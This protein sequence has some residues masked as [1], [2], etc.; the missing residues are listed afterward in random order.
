MISTRA[1]EEMNRASKRLRD[2]IGEKLSTITISSTSSDEAVFLGQN[3]SK[4]S[5]LIGNLIE[6]RIPSLLSQDASR[7]SLK[8]KRQDP[9]FPDAVLFD[10]GT[11]TG[12][13]FEVKAWFPMTTEI[14]GRF[15]ESQ[16]LLAGKDIRVAVVA[17]M[18]SDIVFGTPQIVGILVADAL[19]IAR[20]RDQHYHNPPYYICE[21][22]QD[23][24][25]RTR[26]LQQ[27]NV[28]GFKL[29]D[30]DIN[31]LHAVMNLS[32]LSDAT[33]S[34]TEEGRALSRDLLA[35][36]TYRQDSNFAK[37]DRIKHPEVEGFK[38]NI[39]AQ[40]FRGRPIADWAKDVRTLT[41]NNDKTPAE[42]L[43]LAVE[44]IEGLYGAQHT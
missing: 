20:A 42:A 8:W 19:S 21:E 10:E 2:S 17:W 35:T 1:K 26:N 28:L 12:A 4:L 34:E 15:R 3:V 38:A 31:R 25:S 33:D 7:G 18:L 27:T 6:R 11:P 16:N 13:G 30:G 44:Q 32:G 40:Q 9:D 14:T 29:Q 24:A 37:I 23:T 39:L 36:A 41:R 22:P 5:P 43:R